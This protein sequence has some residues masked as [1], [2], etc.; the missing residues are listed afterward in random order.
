MIDLHTGTV[1]QRPVSKQF[2]EVS[3][4]RDESAVKQE[5]LEQ[6]LGD[7]ENRA[8]QIITRA[9]KRFEDDPD[10]YLELSRKERNEL[11]KFLFL[12]KYRNLNFFERYNHASIDNY[13]ASDKAKIQEYM[14]RKGLQ[15]PRD[16]WLSNIRAFLEIELDPE[17]KWYH[18][19]KEK[20]YGDDALLFLMHAETTF[21]CFCRPESST[22]EFLLTANAYG[23]FEGPAGM[24]MDVENGRQFHGLYTEWHNFAPLSPTLTIVLRSV[25]LPGGVVDGGEGV[26]THIHSMLQAYHMSAEHASSCLQ[27]LPVERCHTSY[28]RIENK[29]F[30]P[31]PG[32]KN[33]SD[34]DRFYF[35]CFPIPTRHVNL[36]NTVMLEESWKTDYLTFRKGAAA[37]RTLKAYL[38]MTDR[39]FKVF[40]NRNDPG[41]VRMRNLEKALRELGDSAQT[42]CT[43][44]R[45]PNLRTH[46]T[47]FVGAR[48]SAAIKT[49]QPQLMQLYGTLTQGK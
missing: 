31:S 48:V 11:R 22:D 7:L 49:T 23:V 21:M 12:M 25:F 45:L 19:L 4:Y 34:K 18:V 43:M 3:M 36:I 37:A 33:Y 5:D 28:G 42:H 26:R 38:E 14:T 27:D 32:F 44:V 46:M 9:R 13:N 16:V 8:S 10:A 41:L 15:S 17:K 47:T 39:S 24:S 20:A 1:T 40:L 29:H 30:V 2:G 35:R 6:R